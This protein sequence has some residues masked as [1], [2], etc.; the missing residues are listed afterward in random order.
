M[1]TCACASG[2][3]CVDFAAAV[4]DGIE[5]EQQKGSFLPLGL[6]AGDIDGRRY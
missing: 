5:E 4:E 6:Q 3:V 2:Y 1:C